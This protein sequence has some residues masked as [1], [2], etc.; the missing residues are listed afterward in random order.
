MMIL[1]PSQCRAAR[2]WLNIS[3]DELAET[4]KVAT[5]TIALFEMEGRVPRD[6]TLED[7]RRALESLGMGFLFDGP[8]AAG[9]TANESARPILRPRKK[10]GSN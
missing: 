8:R 2:A 9:I 4:S 1:T 3:Q 10:R 5:R 6:R 7:I